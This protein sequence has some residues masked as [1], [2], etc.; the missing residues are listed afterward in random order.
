MRIPRRLLWT[1]AAVL[2]LAGTA[3]FLVDRPAA[4]AG[5]LAGAAG[6]AIF[7]IRMSGPRPHTAWYPELEDT[8]AAV[9]YWKDGCPHCH[10]LLRAVAGDERITWVNI[11]LDEGADAR[12]RELNRGNRFTPTA[13]VGRRVLPDPAPED[14]RELLGDPVP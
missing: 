14:L 9:V 8:S 4:G 2:A 12:V 7:A 3:A 5:L 13:V 10:T 1:L 6:L 11:H